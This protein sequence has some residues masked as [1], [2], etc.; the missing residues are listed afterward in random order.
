MLPKLLVAVAVCIAASQ[1]RADVMVPTVTG[2]VK[3]TAKAPDASHGYP[4][5]SSAINLAAKGYVEE[6]FF[7][8][9]TAN[10]YNLVQ[11]ATGSVADAGHPYKTRIVVRRPATAKKFNGTVLVEW[12]IVT[13]SR[14]LEM[15]WFQSA[16]HFMRGA[17]FNGA[18]YILD[19]AR[20]LTR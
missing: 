1:V 3:V 17:W 16:D 10:K 12:T 14:D 11:G 2:P 13:G 15:D 5:N 7:I 8:E 20:G 9:G 6:E 18:L 19:S 4:F